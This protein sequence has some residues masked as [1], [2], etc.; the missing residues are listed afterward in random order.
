MGEA[1]AAQLAISIARSLNLDQFILKGNSAVLIQ[2]LNFPFSNQD[3]RISPVIMESLNN[4]LFAS[5]REARQSNRNANFCTHSVA[6]CAVAKF[7]SD[8]IPFSYSFP[9]LDNGFNPSLSFL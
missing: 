9:S 1:L 8:S 6:R 2:A 3:R 5:F 4:I 7:H